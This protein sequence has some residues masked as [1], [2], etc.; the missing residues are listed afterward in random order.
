MEEREERRLRKKKERKFNDS[1]RVKIDYEEIPLTDQKVQGLEGVD[2]VI[3]NV[4][5]KFRGLK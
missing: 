4:K 5:K 3:K 1:F 2:E